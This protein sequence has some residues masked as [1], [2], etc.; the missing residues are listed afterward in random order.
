MGLGKWNATKSSPDRKL[1]LSIQSAQR[2]RVLTDA[3]LHLSFVQVGHDYAATF[4]AHRITLWVFVGQRFI[5]ALQ[6]TDQQLRTHAAVGS[7]A[8]DDAGSVDLKGLG[9]INP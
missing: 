9:G 7:G 4:E 3:I 1:A 8:E 2:I 6:D 5:G